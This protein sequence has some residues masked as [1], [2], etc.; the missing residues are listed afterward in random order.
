MEREGQ[1]KYYFV[2]NQNAL[3]FCNSRAEEQSAS[4]YLVWES[5]GIITKPILKYISK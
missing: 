1:R 2:G 3:T 5:D 4:D